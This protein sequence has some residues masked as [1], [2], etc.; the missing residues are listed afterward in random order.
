MEKRKVSQ[1]KEYDFFAP[2]GSV[3][4]NFERQMDVAER[5]YLDLL[6]SLNQARLRQQSTE[7]STTLA[8]VDPPT[9][10][11]KPEPSKRKLLVV[12]G[13]LGTIM[14]IIG[15]IIFVEYFDSTLQSPER[16]ENKTGLTV[17]GALTKDLESKSG[18]LAQANLLLRYV[19]N[20]GNDEVQKKILFIHKNESTEGEW[21]LHFAELLHNQNQ[22]IALAGQVPA[23]HN[24]FPV[25]NVDD[26]KQKNSYDTVIASLPSLANASN[27]IKLLRSV[28][29][30]VIVVAGEHTWTS[31]DNQTISLL[32]KITSKKPYLMLTGIE[33]RRL[34]NWLGEL[35][36]QRSKFRRL[37]KKI[38]KFQFN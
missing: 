36:K 9:S 21:G 28:D 33:E 31:A 29:E 8:T 27:E 6:H 13:W 22:N 26:L 11:L 5:E 7:S 38:I 35:P 25:L 1:E 3:L 37:V 24:G 15:I 19:A 16:A 14:L 10:P 23:S 20:I 34:E 12:I 2:L 18:K 32:E 17:I 4:H 30:T